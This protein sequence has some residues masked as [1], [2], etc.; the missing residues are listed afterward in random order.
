[1]RILSEQF[2][3]ISTFFYILILLYTVAVFSS[4]FFQWEGISIIVRVYL[5]IFSFQVGFIFSQI[6]LD[7]YREIYRGKYG[8]NGELL[9]F[10]YTR[11]IPLLVIYTVIVIF[12]FIFYLKDENWPMRPFLNVFTGRFSN[13]II[14]SLILMIILKIEKS[15][16]VT[17][18]LFLSIGVTYFIIYSIVY[19]LYPDGYPTS[20]LKILNFAIVFFS[21]FFEFFYKRIKLFKLLFL[22]TILSLFFHFMVVGF[23]YSFSRFSKT[24]SYSQVESSLFLLRMG[25]SFPLKKLNEVVGIQSDSTL[26]PDI[27]HFSEKYKMDIKL[28]QEEW[29]RLFEDGDLVMG[30]ALSEYFLKNDITV[31]FESINRLAVRYSVLSGKEL[32][33]SESIIKYAAKHYLEEKERFLSQFESENIFYKKWVLKVIK[34][35]GDIKSVPWLVEKLTDIDREISIT[36]YKVLKKITQEDPAGKLNVREN[37]PAVII[38]FRKRFQQRDRVN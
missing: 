22:T 8:K 28:S 38:H 19:T 18:P 16:K 6:D 1:M 11:I 20:I 35:A 31:S 17:I 3:K 7:S 34:E 24:G 30:E 15:L 13:I 4:L 2:K 32:I 21:L 33:N 25:Y 9:L 10:F 29:S 36:A 26:I 27:I 37:N 5:F 23:Y 12:T 14:Y